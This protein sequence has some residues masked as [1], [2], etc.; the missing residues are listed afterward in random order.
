MFGIQSK[1][2]KHLKKQEN[3]AHTEEK[4]QSVET[5]LEISPMLELADIV[6]A[7]GKYACNEQNEISIEKLETFTQKKQYKFYKSEV[8]YLKNSLDELTD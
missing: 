2:A 5:D 3:T 6:T 7:Q 1:I 8:Q 4:G